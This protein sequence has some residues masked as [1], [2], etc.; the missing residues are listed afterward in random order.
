MPNPLKYTTSIPAGALRHATLGIGVENVQYDSTWKNGISPNTLTSYYLVYEPVSG[1]AV[2]IYA[3]ADAAELIQLAQSKGSPE[4]TEAGALAWFPSN[5]FYPA[6]KVLNNIVTDELVLALNAGT[7]TSYPTSGTNWLDL[8]GEAND[9]TLVNN[10][11][12]NPNGYL[13]L[14]DGGSGN[15]RLEISKPSQLATNQYLT[16]QVLFKLNTLPTVAYGDNSPILG[17]RIGSDY[18]IFAY[19][20]SNNKSH[21]G[22]SY[23]DSRYQS[24]HE[25]VFETEAGRWVQFTHVGIPYESGGYQRGKLMYYINGVL[26]RDEFIS[27]DSNGWAIPN[28]FYGGYDARWFK[29]SDISISK[30]K[31]YNK[32]LTAEEISQNYYQAPIVTDGLVFAI[33]ASNLVSYES[34][35]TTT[36]SLTGSDTGTLSGVIH[37]NS[38]NGSWS[39]G[40]NRNTY[41]KAGGNPGP[42]DLPAWDGYTINI[43]VKRT[44]FGTWQ[45]GTTNYDGIWNY[46][47]NHN[48]SFTGAHTEV[49]AIQGT[50]LSAYTIQMDRWYN[51]IMTHDNTSSSGNHK[52]YIDGNLIQTSNIPNPTYSSG[53]IRQFFIG[54]WDS[55]WSMVGEIGTLQVYDKQLTDS[56]VLQNF[57]AC[58]Q[59]YN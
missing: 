51:V 45:S 7:I 43:W 21:L 5:G 58:T 6:N 50:G 24:G 32:Q 40:S 46:Y 29:Y 35:S 56:E 31:M 36:Y 18:M 20:A 59:K 48:L 30:I 15:E 26:D 16:I 1:A 11:T 10:P 28:P 8:S 27:G 42:F 41:L 54:N 2:R 39:F 47:W 14:N 33:D 13:D 34:G 38:A 49:N 37:S 23:D 22:V 4:T 25:S 44:A 19:P 57:N 12:F 17:A 9:G 55:G 52:V 53:N 3:P